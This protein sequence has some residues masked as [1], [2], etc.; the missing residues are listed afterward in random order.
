M[1]QELNRLYESG[2]LNKEQSLWLRSPKP[3][4][5]LYDLNKDPYELN[6]LVGNPDVQDTLKLLRKVLDDWVKDT[7]DLGRYEEKDLIAEW[8]PDG[9]QLQ[10]PPLEIEEKENGVFL[11][12]KKSDAT[13]VWRQPQ[14]SVWN[15]Y[16]KPLPKG[17][18][19][20]A[21]AERIGYKDS[22]ELVY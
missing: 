7:N 4:E 18:S 2:E 14:D 6:N 5:E 19:F 11:F 12:S 16:T 9:N 22:G 1:M 20:V 17:L 13:I 21:K 3:A 8:V 15:I 10:L